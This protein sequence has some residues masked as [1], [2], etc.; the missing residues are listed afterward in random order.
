MPQ[1][2]AQRFCRTSGFAYVLLLVAISVIGIVAAATLSLGSQLAR[3]DAEQSL[4]TIGMEFQ[5]ALR[6]YAAVPVGAIGITNARGPRT[7]EELLKDPR[8]PSIRR[9]L[10]QIYA[11]PMTGQDTWGLVKDPAGYILAVYSLADTKPIKQTGFEP[12]LASFEESKTYAT[13]VFG[14]PNAQLRNT[15]RS[16]TTLPISPPLTAASTQR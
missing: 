2:I 13:W 12:I 11:D 8:I 6:S 15:S 5:Q 16:I 14:L 7:L 1:R 3:R 9:H 4:L 10:R